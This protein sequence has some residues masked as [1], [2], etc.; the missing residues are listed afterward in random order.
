MDNQEMKKHIATYKMLQEIPALKM[1]CPR[2]G[3][4]Q[5]NKNMAK[6]ALSCQKNGLPSSVSAFNLALER[7]CKRSGVRKATVHS[8]RHIFATVLMEK[9]VP[10]VKISAVLGHSSIHTT[11]EFYCDVLDEKEKIKDY[12]NDTFSVEEMEEDD[13]S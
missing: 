3:K 10:L 11:F 1:P 4:Q 13:E 5:M 8:L 6:N 12:I 7:A 2:C 9:G